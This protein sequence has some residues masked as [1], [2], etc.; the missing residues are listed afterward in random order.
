MITELISLTAL[1]SGHDSAPPR[2]NG[3]FGDPGSLEFIEDS[4]PL[5]V[6]R[7]KSR[8]RPRVEL[9]VSPALIFECKKFAL[10]PAIMLP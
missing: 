4:S 1:S 2:A 3:V 10:S 6:P 7:A 5:A 9:L 8:S